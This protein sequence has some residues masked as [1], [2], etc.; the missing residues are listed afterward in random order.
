MV[1]RR[2]AASLRRPW[3]SIIAVPLLL[4]SVGC[5]GS[6]D[7]EDSC[8]PD[9]QDG[10]IGGAHTVLLTVSD[11]AFAVGGVGSGSTQRNITIQNASNVT[12]TLTN[13]GTTPHS[14]VVECIPSELPEACPQTSCFPTEA[15]IAPIGPG[16]SRT[17]MFTVPV[18]EGAYPFSSDVAGD[19]ALVGQF[20]VN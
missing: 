13:V 5:S 4:A 15:D 20:V 9:D 17:V 2:L 19:E 7:D 16:E 14:F 18:V 11:T 3:S 8:A 10:V 12:L 1:S 6:G